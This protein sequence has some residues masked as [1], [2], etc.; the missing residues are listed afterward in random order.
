MKLGVAILV[1]CCGTA[2]C[3]PL[4]DFFPFGSGQRDS[5]LPR[6]DDSSSPAIDLSVTFP[7]F[8]KNY[9]VVYVSYV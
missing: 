7:Y 2:I 6:N 3:I 4:R 1:A 8:D 9:R 5:A